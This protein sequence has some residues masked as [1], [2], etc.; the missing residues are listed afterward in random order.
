MAKARE[1]R[2]KEFFTRMMY[3]EDRKK[4]SVRDKASYAEF[5][6]GNPGHCDVV[7]VVDAIKFT[8]GSYDPEVY[9]LILEDRA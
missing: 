4:A 7:S 6:M 3:L 2:E 9:S 5:V 1:T 8:C